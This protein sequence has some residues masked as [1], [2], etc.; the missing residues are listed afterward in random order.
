MTEGKGS[1]NVAKA[2]QTGVWL[3]LRSPGG[4]SG[5]FWADGQ[6]HSWD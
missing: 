2:V 5:K 4:P 6:E 3:A 1:E